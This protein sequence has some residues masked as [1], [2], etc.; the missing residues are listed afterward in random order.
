MSTV[1]FQ[2]V[3]VNKNKQNTK[4]VCKHVHAHLNSPLERDYNSFQD[5]QSK[6]AT[7]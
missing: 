4:Y 7:K 6:K 1:S 5:A 2:E 3:C